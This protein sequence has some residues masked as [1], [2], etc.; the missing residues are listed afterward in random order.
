MGVC[1][2]PLETSYLAPPFDWSG[3]FFQICVQIAR[4]IPYLCVHAC[5]INVG[6][7]VRNNWIRVLG[8]FKGLGGATPTCCRWDFW[9]RP[10]V[11]VRGGS[12]MHTRKHSFSHRAGR[13][14]WNVVV[15]QRAFWSCVR[16]VDYSQNWN[17][18]ESQ[19]TLWYYRGKN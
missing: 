13:N 11:R 1:L 14:L 4:H 9:R 5:A 8:G 7:A 16:S 19:T 17:G 6:F 2:R 18:P 3:F 12:C 15:S 10:R